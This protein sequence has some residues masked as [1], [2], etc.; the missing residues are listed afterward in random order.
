MTTK[1][2]QLMGAAIDLLLAAGFVSAGR[3][4]EET[5]RIP[6]KASPVYGRSGG[7]LAKLG[8]RQRFVKPGT[9]IKATVGPRTTALYRVEGQGLD[10]VQGIATRD[11]KDLDGIRSVLQSL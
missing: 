4:R 7:E 8:G 10:G 9:T 3:T 6:T 2:E 1:S 11:T 5:V